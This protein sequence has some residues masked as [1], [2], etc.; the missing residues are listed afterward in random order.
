MLVT[1]NIY[2]FGA[3]IGIFLLA[4]SSILFAVFQGAWTLT[5]APLNAF[6]ISCILLSLEAYSRLRP[7]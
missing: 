2:R 3:G 1:P 6:I 5:W 7:S 4:G